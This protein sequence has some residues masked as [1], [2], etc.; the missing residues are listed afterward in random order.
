MS[1]AGLE[2]QQ[3]WTLLLCRLSFSFLFLFYSLSKHSNIVYHSKKTLPSD[4][5]GV[6]S[7]AII[8]A[9][10]HN[11]VIGDVAL[12]TVT[13]QQG[14]IQQQQGQQERLEQDRDFLA[15]KGRY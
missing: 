1:P 15:Y 11:T 10:S 7:T 9:E 13:E 5:I 12:T 6:E 3:V 2:S 14:E 8:R 4:N